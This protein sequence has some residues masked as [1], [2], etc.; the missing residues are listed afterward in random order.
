VDTEK[1]YL[2]FPEDRYEIPSWSATLPANSADPYV[3]VAVHVNQQGL[4]P[5]STYFIPIAIQSVSR[6]EV[7]P[8][9]SNMLLR[10][11]VI[12]DYA[13]HV[14]ATTIY[15]MKGTI[16]SGATSTAVTGSKTVRPLSADEVRFYAGIQTE[17]NQ[18]T[19]EEIARYALI[20]KINSDNTVSLRPYGTIEVEMLALEGYNRYYTLYDELTGRDIQYMD[21]YYRYRT[22]QTPSTPENPATWSNWTEVREMLQ[23]ANYPNVIK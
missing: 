5:D 18:R 9:K 8:D 6:Y 3:N 17:T 19:V 15:T 16:T 23:R 11:S 1:Y 2:L 12:N 22:L 13:E 20:A 4:S 21:L 7:N 14:P 10:I